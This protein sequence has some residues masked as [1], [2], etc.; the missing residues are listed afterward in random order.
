MDAARACPYASELSFERT[1]V[2]L[3]SSQLL[4]AR[5]RG[6]QPR[7]HGCMVS[8]LTEHEKRKKNR[9]RYVHLILVA[10]FVGDVDVSVDV[11]GGNMVQSTRHRVGARRAAACCVVFAVWCD[12]ALS[13]AL[14]QGVFV[15]HRLSSGI[16][17]QDFLGGSEDV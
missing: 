6:Y 17:L 2:R 10:E 8:Y 7:L 9:D 16:F 5:E 4:A 12:V 15:L 11:W 13:V 1:R 3:G 14:G